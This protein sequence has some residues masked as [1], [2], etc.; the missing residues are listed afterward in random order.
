MGSDAYAVVAAKI[1]TFLAFVMM[2]KHSE[3]TAVNA[4][5]IPSLLPMLST[6]YSAIIEDIGNKDEIIVPKR[7]RTRAI[8]ESE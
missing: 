1:S 6:K 5:M 7:S 8:F 2:A 4:A 3:N